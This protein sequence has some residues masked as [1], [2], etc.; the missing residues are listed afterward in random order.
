MI[1]TFTPDW[2][3]GL[4]HGDARTPSYRTLGGYYPGVLADYVS[5]PA[6]WFVHGPETL[7]HP[8][9]STL[10]CAGL[11]AWFALAE[12][13]RAR[14]GD[15]VLVEGTGGVSLFGIQI[16]KAL[17]AEVIVSG[18]AHKL[19][20]SRSLTIAARTASSRWWVG[21]ISARPSRRRPSAGRSS[22]SVRWKAST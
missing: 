1:S 8:E 11:T 3:D 10:P 9:A 6:E 5:F 4:R 16:A 20:S 13:G 21:P 2:V 7:D 19:P 14:A 12:R 18:S 22:R 17:G 15:T